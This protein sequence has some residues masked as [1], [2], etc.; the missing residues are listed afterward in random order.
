MLLSG[1]DDKVGLKAL[2]RLDSSSGRM[3]DHADSSVV[4]LACISR[5]LLVGTSG[6]LKDAE[7][8]DKGL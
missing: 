8:T 3:G 5:F 4:V 6:I 1:D 7:G 2:I